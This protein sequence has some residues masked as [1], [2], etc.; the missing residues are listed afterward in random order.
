MF[1]IKNSRNLPS[2]L[3]PNSAG[4]VFGRIHRGPPGPDDDTG[5]ASS[6]AKDRR[7]WFGWMDYERAAR[8]GPA[9]RTTRSEGSGSRPVSRVLSR[10]VIHLRR[11]SPYA[12]SDLPGSG[13]GHASSPT[14][15]ALP[16]LVLLRVGFT[17]PPVL[18]PA[19]CAL[20]APFHPYP[21]SSRTHTALIA[22]AHTALLRGHEAVCFLWHFPWARAPQALPGTLPFGARTFLRLEIRGSDCP[23]GSRSAQC[24]TRA[25][26]FKTT[27]IS[28]GRSGQAGIRPRKRHD[29]MPRPLELPG[30]RIVN[31]CLGT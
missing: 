17:L 7:M 29:W 11:T 1:I 28:V 22:R 10:A 21:A 2:S 23:V 9:K 19:R 31:S 26:R 15:D 16:Y 18:P 27:A 5:R 8:S 3:D 30:N 14:G 12:C 4:A 13:A 24:D 20:T 25:P 6:A